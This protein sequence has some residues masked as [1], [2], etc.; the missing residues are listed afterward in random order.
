HSEPGPGGGLPPVAGLP[1]SRPRWQADLVTEQQGIEALTLRP[2]AQPASLPLCHAPPAGA[3]RPPPTL[4][5]SGTPGRSGTGLKGQLTL[6]RRS[7]GFPSP[8]PCPPPRPKDRF[9]LG[10]GYQMPYFFG[11]ISV[12]F[13]VLG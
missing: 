8:L 11:Q 3:A 4:T 6:R 9:T 13:P 10:G 7:P 5:S 12:G 2:L 1:L